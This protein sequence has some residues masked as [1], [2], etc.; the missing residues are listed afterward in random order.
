MD[1]RRYAL[2]LATVARII[3]AADVT[4]LPSAPAVVLG[5]IGGVG[6]R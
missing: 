6:R 1:G 4:P 5:A 3:Y 2:P